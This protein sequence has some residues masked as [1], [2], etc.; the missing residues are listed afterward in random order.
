MTIKERLYKVWELYQTGYY[1]NYEEYSQ[2]CLAV[3]AEF[4]SKI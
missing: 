2:A 1:K 3:L 4:G